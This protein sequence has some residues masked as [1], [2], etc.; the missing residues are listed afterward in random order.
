MVGYVP[1]KFYSKF[2]PKKTILIGGIL[3]TASHILAAVILNADLGKTPATVLLFVIGVL[4]GQGACIIFLTALGAMLKQHSI[5]C[6]SL[7][8]ILF[9]TLNVSID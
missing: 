4:G 8:I 6:T 2:G 3:L 9:V 7:V 5:I 1:A